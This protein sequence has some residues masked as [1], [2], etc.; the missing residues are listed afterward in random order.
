MSEDDEWSPE[1]NALTAQWLVHKRLDR[2][3]EKMPA[4]AFTSFAQCLDLILA[5]WE[6]IAKN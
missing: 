1:K 5:P 2:L 6:T 4:D 3:R